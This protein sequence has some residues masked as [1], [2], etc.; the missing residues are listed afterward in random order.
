MRSSLATKLRAVCDHTHCKAVSLNEGKDCGPLFHVP[1]I[2]KI[3]FK[4][5]NKTN[6]FGS[7]CPLSVYRVINLMLKE[8]KEFVI[9]LFNNKT[10]KTRRRKIEKKNLY[11]YF[12]RLISYRNNEVS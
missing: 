2:T 12:R 5:I 3:L 10:D 9:F 11:L 4:V 1:K 7:V 8:C 6:L